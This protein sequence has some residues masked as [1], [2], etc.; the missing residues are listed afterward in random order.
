MLLISQEMKVSPTAISKDQVA[1][2][3]KT[4]SCQLH[5]N[6]SEKVEFKCQIEIIICAIN[7]SKFACSV[8]S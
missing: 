1:D 8:D 4:K 6:K 5:C 2:Q 7:M 3:I